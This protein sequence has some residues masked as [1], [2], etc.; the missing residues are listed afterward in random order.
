I[1]LWG[2]VRNKETGEP[3]ETDTIGGKEKEYET[4]AHSLPGGPV[5]EDAAPGGGRVSFSPAQ[6]HDS[7]LDRSRCDQGARS[8]QRAQSDHWGVT[9]VH[10]VPHCLPGKSRR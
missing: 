1:D 5:S 7:W 6:V 3:W 10:G 9:V 8:P 4:A 2:G